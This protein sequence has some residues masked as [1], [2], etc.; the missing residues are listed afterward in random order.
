MIYIDINNLKALNENFGHNIADLILKSFSKSINYLI[1]AEGELA[2]LAGEEFAIL[3][4]D[5]DDIK[6]IEKYV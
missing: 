1:S 4:N 3:I 6:R 5:F 2:R